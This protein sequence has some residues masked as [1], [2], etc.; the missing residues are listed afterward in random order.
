ME[1]RIFNHPIRK[2]VTDE[3][4]P[5]KIDIDEFKIHI[6]KPFEAFK[7]NMIVLGGEAIENKYIEEWVEQ[8]LAWLDI[9]EER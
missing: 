1:R 4:Y 7:Q 5:D 6:V 2:G 9:E 8:Y 3:F